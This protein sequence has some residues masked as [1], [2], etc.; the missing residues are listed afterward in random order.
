LE[1][2]RIYRVRIIHDEY[3]LLFLEHIQVTDIKII[4]DH[5]NPIDG[6]VFATS[7]PEE[8]AEPHGRSSYAPVEEIGNPYHDKDLKGH[9]IESV[10]SGEVVDDPAYPRPTEEE[11]TT[12]RKVADNI[13][14]VS[15]ALC[16]VE[17]A[18][19]ASYY[20][21]T[22][23]FSNF[24]QF[25][26]PA[27]GNGAGAT[28]KGTQ[29]TAGALNLGLQFANAFVLLFTFLAYVIPILGAWI[30][31]T[32]LGRYKTIAIGVL[33]CGIAHVILIFGAIPSVL[34]AGHGLAPYMIGFFILAFGAGMSF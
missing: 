25:P 26:L 32:R 6:S 8:F 22:T 27:G 2:I 5:A 18:E 23:V 4:A 13:P 12:L 16:A 24:M 30:A 11:K 31:D 29:E 1:D 21:V 10:P 33:I 3:V 9:D 34:Q 28:P 20:G 14:A 15:F 17:F 19:R 7:V